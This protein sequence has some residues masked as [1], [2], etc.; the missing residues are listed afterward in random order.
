VPP[1]LTFPRRPGRPGAGVGVFTLAKG[2]V[3]AEASVGGQK[4][5]YRPFHKAVTTS[6]R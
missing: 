3:M 2:G 4:F 5:S 6:S 1:K